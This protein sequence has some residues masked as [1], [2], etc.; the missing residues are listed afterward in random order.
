[1]T[2]SIN[3]GRPLAETDPRHPVCQD[4]KALVAKIKGEEAPANGNG[5][6]RGWLKWLGGKK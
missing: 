4:L 2:R 1:V 5:L 6:E 3:E